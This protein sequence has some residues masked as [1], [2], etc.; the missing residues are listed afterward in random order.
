M[1]GNFY[2]WCWDVYEQFTDTEYDPVGPNT[3]FSRIIR[4]GFYGSTTSYVTVVRRNA[5]EPTYDYHEWWEAV[6]DI[7]NKLVGFRVVRTIP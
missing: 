1:S 6:E 3:G 7:S 5:K 4:G 2:E